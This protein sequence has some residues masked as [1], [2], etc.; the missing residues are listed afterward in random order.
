MLKTIR[1]VP[2]ILQK[3]EIKLLIFKQDINLISSRL[4]DYDLELYT[5]DIRSLLEFVQE[6][7]I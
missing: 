7:F 2:M 6:L 4:V 1:N 3:Y 5:E